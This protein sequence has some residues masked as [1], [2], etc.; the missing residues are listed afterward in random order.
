MR[1]HEVPTHVQAE[2]RVLL[3][4]TFP[5]IVAM[6]AV[7][8]LSY[9]LYHYAPVG[10]SGVRIALAALFALAGLALVAGRIG[11]RRLPVVAADL[12]RYAVGA[13][14]Y[15]GP[16]SELA[17]AEPP[18]PASPSEPKGDPLRLLARRVLRRTRRASQKRKEGERRNGR[19]PFRRRTAGKQPGSERRAS[20]DEREQRRGFWKSFLIAIALA[21]VVLGVLPL[22]VALADSPADEGWFSEEIE[23]QPP[24]AVPGQRLFVEGL[25]VSGERAEVVLRAA[26][27]LDLVVRAYGGPGGGGAATTPSPR[28]TKASARATT[29]PCRAR[30][31]RSSSHGRTSW[32]RRAPSV[33]RASSC[34]GRCR[35][36]RGSCAPCGSPRSAGRRAFSRAWS[37]RRARARSRRRSSCRRR[38]GTPR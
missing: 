14:R 22:A 29:C 32:G 18:A 2:D 35:R 25:T 36:P 9:G 20:P 34:P 24:P 26:A 15:A 13:R 37:P 17:R 30:R 3:W 7:A 4:F 31:R 23:F 38:P 27:D 11:G 1:E 16:P 12:L 19:L 28:S 6:T 21:L 10:P 5:Q 8:A 33:S